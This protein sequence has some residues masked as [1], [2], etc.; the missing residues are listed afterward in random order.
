MALSRI[1]ITFNEHLQENDFVSFF[2]NAT[3]LLETWKLSAVNPNEVNVGVP[4]SEVGAVS[5]RNYVSSFISD[6]GTTNYSITKNANVVRVTATN[7]SI[8]FSSP[9]TNADVTFLIDS[10]ATEDEEFAPILTNIDS[11][12]KIF[13]ADSPIHFNFQND[14]SDASIQQVTVEVYIWR[15]FQTADLPTTPAVIFN[16]IKKISPH[17]NYIAIELHN[18]IK[19]YITSSNLNKNNP[20]WAYNTTEKATTAGEG[21]YFHIV[22]KVDNESVKQLGTY[23]ATTGYRYSFEQKGGMY[24]TFI[25]TETFRRYAKN[26]RYDNCEI[27]LTTVASTSQ[28]GT[29]INGMIIQKKVTP[30]LRETQTG[31]PCLIAYV[32]RLGLWDTFTP[33][34]KFTESEEIKRDEYSNSFRNPLNVNSQ[35]QHLKQNGSAKGVRKFTINTGL[36]DERNNYQVREILQSSKIYLVIFE[37][38]VF[39]TESIGLTVDS[40]IVTADNTEITADSVTVTSDDLGNYSSFTQIPVK[41]IT[42]DFILKTRLNDKSSIHY[43][44]EFEETNNFINDIL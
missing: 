18:E 4:G 3:E 13:L 30:T 42:K 5:A 44:L 9:T 33:F 25:N 41:N 21:V 7:E 27:N 39:E 32:N 23:F 40:T 14:A 2:S 34:G 12:S 20:Q 26:I 15:G 31:V 38:N 10:V 37:G 36:L 43:T 19:A 35:I 16:N 1:T 8:V 11:K 22:Y 29:G 28:S 6:F 17:D 24:N